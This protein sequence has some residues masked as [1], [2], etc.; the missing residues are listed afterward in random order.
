VSDPWSRGT[1]TTSSLLDVIENIGSNDSLILLK[2]VQN[3]EILGPSVTQVI[4][5]IVSIVGTRFRE[6]Y[7]VGRATLL[8][9]SPGRITSYHM[10][11]DTNFLFQIRGH[12][13]LHVFD[14]TDRTLLTAVELG[15][16]FDGNINAARYRPHRQK[17]AISYELQPG[18]AV[19]IPFT[20]PHWAQ[21][22][23]DVSIALSINFDLRSTARVAR[24]HRVNHHLRKLGVAPSNP[25]T[26][27]WSDRLK[28]LA[29]FS[30]HAV[31]PAYTAGKHYIQT[32]LRGTSS[33]A[34]RPG[35][36]HFH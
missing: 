21:N 8:I 24:I 2:H 32:L 36:R 26:A 13:V 3:D 27:P 35:H 22:R 25:G 9:A 23:S 16:F 30:L 15:Q 4:Q 19:H 1:N 18:S 29:S 17:D 34:A 33:L 12:K 6:D 14:H 28:V 7:L 20:A 31:K 5:Q 10:D 11:G